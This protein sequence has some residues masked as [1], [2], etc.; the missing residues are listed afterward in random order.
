M[1]AYTAVVFCTILI[2]CTP[3]RAQTAD[4]VV[5]YLDTLGYTESPTMPGVY[6][7][8]VRVLNFD[9]IAGFQIEF[10]ISGTDVTFEGDG[11]I[12]SVFI[13]S[14][15]GYMRIGDTTLATLLI[16]FDFNNIEGTTIEDGGLIFELL[17]RLD[18]ESGDCFPVRVDVLDFVKADN[19]AVSL[20]AIG[21][22]GN[23][24]LVAEVAVSGAVRSP[25]ERSL[26][27]VEV[28]LETTD[29]TYTTVTNASGQYIFEA[30]PTGTPFV[31]RPT[32]RVTETS[33]A[34]RIR[35]INVADVV[36]I[37]RHL[38]DVLPL[39]NPL[40]RLAADVNGDASIGL[41]DLTTLAAYILLRADA[42]PGGSFYTFLPTDHVFGDPTNPWA[43][44]PPPHLI[45]VDATNQP[46]SGLDF[47]GI[48]IGDV[49][50]SSY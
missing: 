23:I 47:I 43:D 39:P 38:L 13:P 20:P 21:I 2:A 8:P 3:L 9:S 11:L 26:P 6:A 15:L 46:V 1:A 28:T 49:N 50:R 44:G 32:G 48:K 4:T 27:G 40:D 22:N 42:L 35:G 12:N 5:V 34:D 41:L 24:C 45:S 36:L 25:N 30:I 31:V 18:G 7:I 33:R 19:T 16:D 17:L 37:Q 10:V 14:N 29:S